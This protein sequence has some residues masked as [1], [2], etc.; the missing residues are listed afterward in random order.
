MR[1][2]LKYRRKCKRVGIKQPFNIRDY[3]KNK[4]TNR[5]Y[6]LCQ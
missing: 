3:Y 2:Y 6:I 4:R 5:E 1:K